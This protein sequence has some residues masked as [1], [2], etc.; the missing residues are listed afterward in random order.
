[1]LLEKNEQFCFS[2]KYSHTAFLIFSQ[3]SNV[4]IYKR[5]KK[6][7]WY[8]H[9]VWLHPHTSSGRQIVLRYLINVFEDKTLQIQVAISLYLLQVLENAKKEEVISVRTKGLQT[10]RIHTSCKSKVF[11]LWSR[12][13]ECP[14]RRRVIWFQDLFPSSA[15]C[16]EF[17][18]RSG[19]CELHIPFI[20]NT[21][22]IPPCHSWVLPF[23]HFETTQRQHEVAQTRHTHFVSHVQGWG[24][25]GRLGEAREEMS[26]FCLHR[27]DKSNT[28][29]LWFVSAPSVCPAGVQLIICQQYAWALHLH[30]CVYI[31]IDIYRYHDWLFLN[32]AMIQGCEKK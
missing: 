8:H 31:Y 1:M 22:F 19:G 3:I 27:W 13:T 12:N 15:W 10:N 20:Q 17:P 23:P 7:I 28:E 18:R 2:K 9:R 16:T 14:F 30:V 6:K 26:Q 24:V 29:S 32:F 25:G 4:K 11:Y 5:S 21:V